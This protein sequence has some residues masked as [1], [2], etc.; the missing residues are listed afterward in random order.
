MFRGDLVVV[1]L[2]GNHGKPRPALVVQAD[3]LTDRRS[4]P[5]FPITSHLIEAV[6]PQ[7][8]PAARG[9]AAANRGWRTRALN[10][11]MAA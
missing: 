2:L 7:S 1:S 6:S 3:R 5:A 11:M 10:A 9:P 4:V 8:I